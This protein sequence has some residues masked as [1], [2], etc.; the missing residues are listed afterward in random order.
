MA[1]QP[2]I[3]LPLPPRWPRHVRSAAIHA[4]ALARLALTT[5]RGQANFANPG[6]GR[7][8][9]LTEQLLLIKEE[10]RI[11]DARMASIP[12]VPTK[13][14]IHPLDSGI[15]IVPSILHFSPSSAEMGYTPI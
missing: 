1:T 14:L 4:V 5:A 15:C 6:S 8:A 3:S 10:L 2:R 12:A 7:I 9:R 13:N 11:K